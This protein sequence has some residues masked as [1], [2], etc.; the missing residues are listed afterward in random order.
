MSR[1]ISWFSC[2]AASAVASKLAI[3]SFAPVPVIIANCDTRMSEHPDN[4]RFS[5]DC[6]KWF[7]QPIVY[8]RNK[9]YR[10]VDEVFIQ[11]KYMSGIRGARC[12]TELKKIPRLKFAE[13][14]DIHIFGFTYDEKKRVRDF[15][16]RNPDMLL[17]W[18][19]VDNFI[20]KQG[21]YTMLKDAGIELPQMYKLGFDNNNCPGCVKASS[22][23]YWDL[24][25]L[26]FPEIFRRRCEQS[27]AIGCRLVQ[28]KGKRIFLDE[29]PAGPFKKHKRKENLS[30]GPECGVQL[31]LI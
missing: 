24:V 5:K 20:T 3:A 14:D 9:E 27:R 28:F 17:K 4:Y 21:C 30:C 2:G 10:D 15:E 25:R 11:T 13:P 16:Q 22:P 1:V 19:L 12:T 31:K 29:L 26:N 18:I 23:Y 6:E 7:G 8:L